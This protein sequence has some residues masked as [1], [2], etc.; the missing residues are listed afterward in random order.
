M[1]PFAKVA[2]VSFLII[3][4]QLTDKYWQCL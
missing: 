3:Q 2:P 1:H 4:I